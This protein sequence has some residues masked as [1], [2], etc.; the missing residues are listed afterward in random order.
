MVFAQRVLDN[1]HGTFIVIAG[2]VTIKK[3]KKKR[4]S[5]R[6]K[7]RGMRVMKSSW[8]AF[9]ACPNGMIAPPRSV[10]NFVDEIPSLAL[11]T[12]ALEEISKEISGDEDDAMAG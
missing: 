8:I 7:Y 12:L 5:E 10:L 1:N 3:K 2:V 4:E 11:D 9:R 6:R